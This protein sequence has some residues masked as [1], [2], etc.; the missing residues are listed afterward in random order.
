MKSRPHDDGGGS[1]ESLPCT[2][3]TPGCGQVPE[4]Q[5]EAGVGLR[6][7]SAQTARREAHTNGKLPQSQS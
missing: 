3:E 6:R 1:A 2:P 7:T 5:P 4:T